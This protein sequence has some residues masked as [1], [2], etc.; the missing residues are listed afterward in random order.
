[1]NV[2]FRMPKLLLEPTANQGGRPRE[3]MGRRACQP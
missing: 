3:H 1:M 2:K